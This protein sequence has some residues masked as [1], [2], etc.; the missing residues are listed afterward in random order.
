MTDDTLSCLMHALQDP[1]V[2]DHAVGRFTLLQT[3]ISYILLTGP[4]AYKIKKPVNL[5]F[6]D[7]SSLD[8]RRFYCEEEVRL[9]RRLSPELYLGVVPITGTPNAPR[10]GGAGPVIEYAVKM[11]QFDPRQQLDRVLDRGELTIAHLE[12]LADDVASFHAAAAVAGPETAFGDPAHVR[13]PI[14]ENFDQIAPCLTDPS[15]LTRGKALENWSQ[16]TLADHNET[17]A[18]RK[19]DGWVRECHGDMHLANMALHDGKVMLF[20]C[21]EFNANLRWIDVMSEAAFLVM[22]LDYRGRSDLARRFR[23]RYLERNGD[24]AGLA[25]LRHYL[26]YRAMVRAKV[27]C[28]RSAQQDIEPDQRRA[29]TAEFAQHLALAEDYTRP[30]TPRLVITHGLSGSGKTT[31][32]D[33]L[34]GVWDA[35]RVRSDIER[36]RLHGLAASQSSGSG[37]ATGLY[38]ASASDV[39]YARLEQTAAQIIGAGYSAIVDATFLSR[40]R[41][42]RFAALARELDV[43]FVIVHCDA[44]VADLRRRIQER[45]VRGRDASEAGLAVLEHQLAS[46]EPLSPDERAHVVDAGTGK[47]VDAN[48]LLRRIVAL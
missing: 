41:R 31:I 37:I 15:L 14:E 48:A 38:T 20:D 23:N 26:V 22:D 46:Q 40:A 6:L 5:G 45:A 32:T 2:Y 35:V 8:R 17:F 4:Y 29:A 34:I 10:L 21:L 7:F 1:A 47:P 3:H 18:Q 42:A 13:H 39:T 43:P 30:T 36:K 44:P 16:T 25:L 11:V 12:Q 19:R 28:I 24:Y 27:A 9:N 33:G